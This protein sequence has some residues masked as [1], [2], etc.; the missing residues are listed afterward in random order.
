MINNT[1]VLGVV[2]VEKLRWK[3]GVFV[4]QWLDVTEVYGTIEYVE[5]DWDAVVEIF[6]NTGIHISVM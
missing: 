5:W 1:V 2:V 3:L 4:S 6:T